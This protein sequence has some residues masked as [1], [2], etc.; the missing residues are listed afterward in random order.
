VLVKLGRNEEAAVLLASLADR[1]PENQQVWLSLGDVL[2]ELKRWPASIDA[3]NNALAAKRDAKTLKFIGR[4]F[5][6]MEHDE[7]A[8]A[9]LREVISGGDEDA[10]TAINAAF[11][12][13]RLNRKDEANELIEEVRQR[14]DLADSDA[15]ACSVALFALGENDRAMQLALPVMPRALRS[16]SPFASL[17]AVI[18]EI[19]A[20]G[21]AD[22]LTEMM[23]N[24]GPHEPMQPLHIALRI[25]SGED[26]VLLKRLAPEKKEAVEALLKEWNVVPVELKKTKKPAT[27]RR[28]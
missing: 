28:S 20:N 15:L 14:T 2:L 7:A 10:L 24:V 18:G 22:V 17:L 26:R 3:Y 13:I 9:L 6:R 4:R 5:L 25:A 27:R 11:G 23:E 8:V 12:L 1:L 16:E 21:K 19:V